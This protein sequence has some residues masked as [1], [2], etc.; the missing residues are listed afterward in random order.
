MEMDLKSGINISDVMDGNEF[1]FFLGSNLFEKVVKRSTLLAPAHK[2]TC[3]VEGEVPSFERDGIASHLFL[4]L[5]Q[6]GVETFSCEKSSGRQPA[7]PGTDDNGIVNL[8]FRH[9]SPL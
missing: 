1:D 5:K 8:G 4:L 3:G 2:G 9:F 7:H 6:K